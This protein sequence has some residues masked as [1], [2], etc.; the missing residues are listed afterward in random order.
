M[1]SQDEWFATMAQAPSVGRPVA[2]H[3]IPMIRNALR[4][5]NRVIDGVTG[6]RAPFSGASISRTSNKTA[7]PP[8]TSTASGNP[9]RNIRHRS[10]TVKGGNS[11]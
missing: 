4:Q 2:R 5:T 9:R 11:G 6:R 3:R 1:S 10:L 8:K 7:N